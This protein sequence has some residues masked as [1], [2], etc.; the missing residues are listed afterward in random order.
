MVRPLLLVFL[1]LFSTPARADPAIVAAFQRAI[2][3]FDRA[4]PALG[5]EAFG[6][7]VKTYREA[8]SR[9]QFSSDFW[10]GA[11]QLDVVRRDTPDGSCSRYAAFVRSPPENGVLGLIICPEFLT[12]GTEALRALTILHEMVHV[13]AGPDECRAMAFAARV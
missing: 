2:A 6:V 1:L 11:V 9:R 13:V 12:P 3:A 8:L 10:G 7:N 4:E 5:A